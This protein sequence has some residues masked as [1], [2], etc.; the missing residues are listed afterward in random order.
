MALGP[1][2]T[3]LGHLDFGNLFEATGNPPIHVGHN[4]LLALVRGFE[5]VIAGTVGVSAV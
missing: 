4:G 5:A 1:Y 2:A 3:I